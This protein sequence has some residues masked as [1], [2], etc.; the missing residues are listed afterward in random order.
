MKDEVKFWRYYIPS[1]DGI[2]GWGVFILDSTGMFAAVTDY[3]NFVYMWPLKYTG[4]DDIREFFKHRD[5]YYVLGKCAPSNGREYQGDK[6]EQNIRETII[7]LRRD[8]SFTEEQARK[9]W[10]LL[11]EVD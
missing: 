11:E 1:I 3:G 4:C 10:D 2:E 8:H 6:T 7:R 9:E 5:A